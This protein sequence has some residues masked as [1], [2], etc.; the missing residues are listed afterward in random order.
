MKRR[1]TFRN[2]VELVLIV[3]MADE[4][5]KAS[6]ESCILRTKFIRR[7]SGRLGVGPH[8]QGTLRADALISSILHCRAL[9]RATMLIPER[10]PKRAWVQ[11]TL[12]INRLLCSLSYARK[13][14]MEA[15]HRL[16]KR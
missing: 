10:D 13:P 7:L 15:R 16:Q 6:Q 5:V 1:T 11:F 14:D 12:P 2:N 9:T 4:S 3:C 8:D